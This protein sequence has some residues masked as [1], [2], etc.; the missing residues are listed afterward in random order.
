MPI[1]T[2]VQNRK[3]QFS[4]YI[5]HQKAIG[6]FPPAGGQAC[7]NIAC[8]PCLRQAG[9]QTGGNDR[10]KGVIPEIFNQESRGGG[11]I[12]SFQKYRKI[13]SNSIIFKKHISYFGQQHA[14]AIS[15]PS[16]RPPV[17]SNFR[18]E[19]CPDSPWQKCYKF[20]LDWRFL[21][22]CSIRSHAP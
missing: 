22:N 2:L 10:E 15:L 5:V 14:Y 3:S 1:L 17:E 7:L 21:E 13:N 6:R 18:W 4:A 19:N 16:S 11:M 20:P 9:R 8:L 12:T